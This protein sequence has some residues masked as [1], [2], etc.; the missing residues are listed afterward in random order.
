MPVIFRMKSHLAES[1]HGL[2]AAMILFAAAFLAT[3]TSVGQTSTGSLI[4]R[5]TDPSQ[6]VILDATV[7]R[8]HNSTNQKLDVH[9]DQI[10]LYAL[11]ALPPG[12]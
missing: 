6:A 5:V 2:R 8:F 12:T 9:S 3:T 4:G 11:S 10:G 7:S 1:V